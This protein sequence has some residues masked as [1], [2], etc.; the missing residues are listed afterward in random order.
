VMGPPLPTIGVG[1]KLELALHMLHT[2]PALLVLSGGRPL[3]VLTRSDILSY[4]ES[5]ASVVDPSVGA[6]GGSDG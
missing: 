4:F 3:S 2:A 6:G 5:R 1:Q